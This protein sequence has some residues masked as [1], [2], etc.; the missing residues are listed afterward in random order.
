MKR[1]H[2]VIFAA[3]LLLSFSLTSCFKDIGRIGFSPKTVDTYEITSG[4]TL[5]INMTVANLMDGEITVSAESD[6][7]D[8]P[9][10]VSK[11]DGDTFTLTVTAPDFIKEQTEV[12][13]PVKVTDVHYSFRDPISS[14]VT[15]IA[16]PDANLY[17]IAK[18]ANCLISEPGKVVCFKAFKGNSGDAVDF[19]SA[20]LIWQDKQNLVTKLMKSDD[21]IVVWLADGVSGNA[22]VGAYTGGELAWTYHVWVTSDNPAATLYE[23]TNGDGVKFSFMDRNVGALDASFDGDAYG[24]YYYW[25]NKNPYAGGLTT[26]YDIEGNALEYSIEETATIC[27]ENELDDIHEYSLT[28]PMTMFFSNSN[29]TGNYEWLFIHKDKAKWTEKA[30]LWGAVSGN[31]SIYD[32]CPEG[33]KVPPFAALDGFKAANATQEKNYN[34][35][36]GNKTF[37][38]WKVTND[39]GSAIL[40]AAGDYNNSVTFEAF[41]DGENTFPTAYFW[42]ADLQIDNFRG[43]ALKGTPTSLTSVGQ[44][45]GYALNV[46]CIKE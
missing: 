5:N 44:A 8:Y 11:I 1:I 36:A 3:G 43:T 31:K 26:L 17:R 23:Y 24:L 2:L 20:N 30:D 32:P 37:I 21:E 27:S 22:L 40:P 4:E 12:K 19:D 35:E 14:T 41:Y 33:Y 38:G 39:S 46:R 9:V 25:G 29:K 28:R 15:V 13:I 6:N 42:A 10:S 7:T 16:K 34:G 18:K 45:M